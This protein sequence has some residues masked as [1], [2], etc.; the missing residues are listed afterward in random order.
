MTHFPALPLL[1]NDAYMMVTFLERI[2]VGLVGISVA[3]FAVD[4]LR[5]AL[6]KPSEKTAIVYGISG[7][8]VAVWLALWA[9]LGLK[10]V[11]LRGFA[12]DVEWLMPAGLVAAQFLFSWLPNRLRNPR[13]QASLVVSFL[14]VS[15]FYILYDTQLLD[16]SFDPMMADFLAWDAFVKLSL[17]VLALGEHLGLEGS[18]AALLE[19]GHVMGR[20][21]V[22]A[23]PFLSILASFLIG[24]WLAGL[25]A[26]GERPAVRKP[27]YRT[28]KYLSF[29]LL[30]AGIGLVL[31]SQHGLTKALLRFDT[32]FGSDVASSY[33]LDTKSQKI[34]APLVD[35]SS[36]C[37]AEN[38][39]I[40]PQRAILEWTG[41]SPFIVAMYH[42]SWRKSA[43]KQKIFA[44]GGESFAVLR[45]GRPSVECEELVKQKLLKSLNDLVWTLKAKPQLKT[46]SFE[47]VT[48]DMTL[49]HHLIHAAMLLVLLVL[50]VSHTSK[51]K[52]RMTSLF[53][54]ISLLIGG[55]F[56]GFAGMEPLAFFFVEIGLA[57][58]F[59][60][61]LALPFRFFPPAKAWAL[62]VAMALGALASDRLVLVLGLAGLISEWMGFHSLGRI[63]PPPG[64]R[65]SV[66]S[67]GFLLISIL[68]LVPI[69]GLT[70]VVEELAVA[71]EDIPTYPARHLTR[72]EW[73]IPAESKVT[74]GEL[75][76]EARAHCTGRGEILSTSQNLLHS[77]L[78][79]LEGE[80]LWIAIT[81]DPLPGDS[82]ML[83]G[84]GVIGTQWPNPEFKAFPRRFVAKST[85]RLRTISPAKVV[86]FCRPKSSGE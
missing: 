58:G 84:G 62:C 77:N 72:A 29:A 53:G 70:H 41:D 23:L 19:F 38:V 2:W 63:S 1:A 21:L 48:I 17:P 25:F 40:Q 18:S 37:P 45:S 24:P 61:V 83:S 11:L 44:H 20:R 32:S 34:L 7:L 75:K 9:D 60:L 68:C 52:P 26:H 35:E 74:L 82:I 78:G 42:D 33:M 6:G 12:P 86:A 56:H 31:V 71:G 54:G 47:E 66:S 80:N 67:G 43:A 57:C 81:D 49:Y 14:L 51:T 15:T 50:A 30:L 64:R 46:V 65:S 4:L 16:A 27:S 36:P 79:A 69:A 8:Y 3:V 76:G 73:D 10:L 5:R 22:E 13:F 55:I 85:T 28:E 59:L 39:S